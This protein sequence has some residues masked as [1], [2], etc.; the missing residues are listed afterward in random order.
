MECFLLGFYN[1]GPYQDPSLMAIYTKMI[2]KQA[3]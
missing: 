1:N 3:L 2:G